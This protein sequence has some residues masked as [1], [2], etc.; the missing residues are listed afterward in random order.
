VFGEDP[1]GF[2]RGA[3]LFLQDAAAVA[4][5]GMPELVGLG[6][7]G[8]DE[9]AGLQ[10]AAFER[11]KDA[12]GG[13]VLMEVGIAGGEAGGAVAVGDE[14]EGE[15]LAGEAAAMAPSAVMVDRAA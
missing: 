14:A 15:P 8:F 5:D 9:P 7:P 2:I 4:D 6:G 10:R 12:G 11:D 13:G 3:E 1:I